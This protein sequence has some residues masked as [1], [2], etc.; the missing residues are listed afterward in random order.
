MSWLHT[1]CG[2]SCGW[3]L[4]AI[5]LTGS[6][7]VFREPITRWMEAAPVLAGIDDDAP[8]ARAVPAALAYLREHAQGAAFWRIELPEQ[9]GDA[10]QITWR[11]AGVDTQVALHPVT[12]ELL[13]GPWKRVTEGGRHFMSFHYMLQWPALGYWVVGWVS[14]GMLVALVSGV[15]IHRRIFQD[16]FTF[17]P[18]RGPRAWLDSH[19]A[20]AVLAL[21]FHLMIVYTGLAI[22]YT[23]YM[24]WPMHAVYGMEESA[25]ARFHDGLVQVDR[26]IPDVPR[27]PQAYPALLEQAGTLMGQPAAMLVI[28][29]PGTQGMRLQVHGRAGPGTGSGGLVQPTGNVTYDGNSGEL[30]DVVPADPRQLSAGDRVQRTVESLHFADYGGWGIR[31]LYFVLGLLGALMAASGTVL[32]ASKRRVKSGQEFGR[33]TAVAYR[34]IDGL[35]IASVTGICLASVG[36]LYA[37]RLLPVTLPDRAGWEIRFFLLAWLAALSHAL[38]RPQRRA[39]IE[40]LWAAAALCALVP[41]LNGLATGQSLLH[42]LSASDWQRASVEGVIL[43]F[44]CLFAHVAWRL[45]Q[46]SATARPARQGQAVAGSR[47]EVAGRV[48]L[49]AVGGY[50]LTALTMALLAQSLVLLAGVHASLAVLVATLLGFAFCSGV[51]VWVFSVRD[52]LLAFKRLMLTVLGLSVIVAVLAAQLMPMAGKS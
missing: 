40:Q 21:P 6:F 36:Y 27:L 11:N 2:L 37:N 7:S 23:S 43:L 18:G 12:G 19:N 39:W 49:A 50:L 15:I 17:R 8:L 51:V 9:A 5:M 38:V 14:M 13:P 10:L 1:W 32:F 20:S 25:H 4:C 34:L 35:N 46:V 31:W 3:L 26:T 29:R 52:G 41:V 30:L 22:F 33:G 47:W 24:P 16:F 42:Y 44:A 48:M 28:I 45:Q